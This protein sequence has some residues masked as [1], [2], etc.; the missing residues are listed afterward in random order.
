MLSIRLG[1]VEL[2]AL[3]GCFTQERGLRLEYPKKFL[4]PAA[5]TEA[6]PSVIAT[7]Q[8]CFCAWRM[9]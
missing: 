4:V 5:K 2:G 9:W 6:S 1:L 7:G 3:P 8:S